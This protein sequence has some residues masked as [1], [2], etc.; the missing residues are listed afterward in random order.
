MAL[1][2]GA[3]SEKFDIDAKLSRSPCM[4]TQRGRKNRL[5]VLH[6]KRMLGLLCQ[7]VNGFPLELFRADWAVETTRSPGWPRVLPLSSTPT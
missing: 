4:G 2:N 6:L 3:Y 1:Q 7:A 5:A